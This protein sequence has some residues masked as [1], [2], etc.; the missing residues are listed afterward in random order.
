MALF[1]V[2]A[3]AEE[4]LS[5]AD[6]KTHLRV[7]VEDEDG[8]ILELIIAARQHVEAFTRRALV[9]QTWD[10]KL[11]GFDDPDYVRDDAIWLPFPPVTSVTSVSY[12]DTSGT[13]QVW[14][15]SNY[16]TDFPSGPHARRARIATA[17]G[18][19]WPST[20][21]VLNAVTIR[22]VCGYGSAMSQPSGIVAA[23]KVLVGH[24]Y[25]SREGAD[26]RVPT[27][28]DALLWPFKAY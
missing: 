24:W 11:C 19:S 6:A 18:V 3:P 25:A 8:L 23:M 17:Y 13:T 14:G 5:L 2:T 21:D 15:S 26:V 27:T 4:P 9:T 7:D 28:V 1:L 12:V 20:R 10:L 16:E 22:F